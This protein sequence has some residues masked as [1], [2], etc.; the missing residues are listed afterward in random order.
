M[1]TGNFLTRVVDQSKP[2]ALLIATA[3]TYRWSL[4][5]GVFPRLCVTGFTYAQP[6]LI[7]TLINY[8]ESSD[9]NFAR[10]DGYGLIAAY[11]IVFFGAAVSYPCKRIREFNVCIP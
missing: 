2:H 10:N 7:N 3:T 6:F 4:L 5:A 1:A 8:L 9:P 11:I